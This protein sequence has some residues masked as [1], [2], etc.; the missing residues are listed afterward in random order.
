MIDGLP[1]ISSVV[2]ARPTNHPL[3]AANASDRLT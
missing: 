3:S 2:H 1:L